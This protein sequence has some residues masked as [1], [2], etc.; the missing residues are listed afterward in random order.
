[1][2]KL[3]L[4]AKIITLKKL[5]QEYQHSLFKKDP[6]LHHPPTAFLKFIGTPYP[7]EGK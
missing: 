4:N 6:L 2:V 7:E 3:F 5:V 1:M